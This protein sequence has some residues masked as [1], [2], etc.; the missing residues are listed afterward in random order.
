[1]DH[2]DSAVD[3]SDVTGELLAGYGESRI[4]VQN[5][6]IKGGTVTA[7][8]ED[9]PRGYGVW[10]AGFPV[11]VDAGGKFMAEEILPEGLHTVELAVLDDNGNGELY[12]RDLEL[13]KS[14][15]FTAGIADMTV[16]GN[17]TNGPADLLAP[18]KP[19]YTD[20]INLN[21]RLAFY[22][23]GKFNNGWSLT[24]SADTGE[25]PLDDIFS[26]FIDRSP[27]ALFRRID[28]DYHY[29]TFGDDSAVI[30]DAPTSGKFYVKVKKDETYALWGN[31]NTGYTDNELAHIDRGLY[32]VN[33]HFQPVKTTDE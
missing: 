16:S 1:M 22:T 29:P 8:G 26:N 17:R 27:G 30:D 13:K 20:D 23:R 32:G 9:V 28:P 11:P 33:I 6:P 5:I 15:W 3:R 2:T 21:G 7:Y 18:D 25:G 19:Q 4:A 24:A 14:D 10:M 31:F 12:L